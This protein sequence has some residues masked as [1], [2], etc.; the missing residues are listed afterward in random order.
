MLV[1]VLIAVA[2]CGGGKSSS[3]AGGDPVSHAPRVFPDDPNAWTC[4]DFDEASSERIAVAINELVASSQ[5]KGKRAE[6]ENQIRA[7]CASSSPDYK[8]AVSA[9]DKTAAANQPPA[10]DATSGGGSVE[11]PADPQRAE[12]QGSLPPSA[13]PTSE[14]PNNGGTT[15]S[16]GC[17]GHKQGQTP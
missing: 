10:Q 12:P 2:G 11:P 3:G 15:K 9:V 6:L 14:S 5:L 7:L 1:C 4:R 17:C 8:P 16:G 13:P